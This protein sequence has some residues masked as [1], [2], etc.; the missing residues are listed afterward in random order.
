MKTIQISKQAG[1]KSTLIG[2]LILLG[3]AG[4]ARLL[5]DYPLR[6]LN[7]DNHQFD[8]NNANDIG[9]GFGLE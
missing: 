4:L 9:E 6:D 7:L 5:M 8:S 3:L 1:L 2:V